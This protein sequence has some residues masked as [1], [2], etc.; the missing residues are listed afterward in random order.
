LEVN[1]GDAPPPQPHREPREEALN[2]FIALK[3]VASHEE[4]NTRHHRRT[5]SISASPPFHTHLIMPKIFLLIP[6][7]RVADRRE[8]HV[9][10]PALERALR[11]AALT[12]LS[13]W[14][15]WT[16]AS[17]TTTPSA[18]CRPLSIYPQVPHP[19]AQ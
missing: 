7:S 12:S 3:S 19:M 6:S 4:D 11:V 17:Q 2:L 1:P 8:R 5:I 9:S 15:Q 18:S 10:S 13:F 16:V 14:L